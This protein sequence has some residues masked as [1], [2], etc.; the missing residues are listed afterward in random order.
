VILPVTRSHKRT[1]DGVTRR[2]FERPNAF[3]SRAR[4]GSLSDRRK[5]PTSKGKGGRGREERDGSKERGRVAGGDCL[6]FI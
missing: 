5:G 4:C 6:L 2:V 1:K 3:D